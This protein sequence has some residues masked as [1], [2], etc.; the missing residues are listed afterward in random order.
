[1][2]RIYVLEPREVIS[3]FTVS[4]KSEAEC[5]CID[6]LHKAYYDV[7][8]RSRIMTFRKIEINKEINSGVDATDSA[9]EVQEHVALRTRIIA[10][11]ESPIDALQFM[12]S[13]L[14]F[15]WYTTHEDVLILKMVHSVS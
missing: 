9:Y 11:F 5:L 7:P 6:S 2:F 14:N 1:M 4:Y 8:Y 12:N 13:K 15:Q 10:E 3:S